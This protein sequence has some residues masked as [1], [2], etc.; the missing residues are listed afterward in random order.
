MTDIKTNPLSPKE[1]KEKSE[2]IAESNIPNEVIECFN[3]LIVKN[4]VGDCSI[5]CQDN[6]VN[7]I[8]KRTN[9]SR[10]DIFSNKY[11]DIESLYEK[12]GWSVFYNKSPYYSDKPSFFRFTKK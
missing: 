2:K 12:V 1:A 8:H 3:E 11:L 9:I 5:V 7:L 10:D 4:I 6:I